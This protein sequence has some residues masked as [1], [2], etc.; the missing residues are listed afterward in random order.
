MIISA[1]NQRQCQRRK[2]N[3]RIFSEK[4]FSI[5]HFK[6]ISCD[7]I[8]PF[9]CCGK[10]KLW[11]EVG[12]ESIASSLAPA[13]MASR[14]GYCRRQLTNSRWPPPLSICQASHLLISQSS[15]FNIMQVP[16]CRRTK[17]STYTSVYKHTCRN[18]HILTVCINGTV[19]QKC[20]SD[21]SNTTQ[22]SFFDRVRFISSFFIS[23]SAMDQTLP[24]QCQAHDVDRT[25]FWNMTK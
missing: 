18:A 14:S 20:E 24:V 11:C 25:C 4:C 10:L 23:I 9:L 22:I 15:V 1:N 17:R 5:E 12:M 7:K 19:P 3:N 21:P 13:R 6:P 2:E 8:R 16:A